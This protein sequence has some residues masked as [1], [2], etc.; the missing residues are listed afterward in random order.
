M[1]NL[2]VFIPNDPN[3]QAKHDQS[4]INYPEIVFAPHEY[5]VIDVKRSAW[6]VARIWF[7]ALIMAILF[8]VFTVLVGQNVPG[9]QILTTSLLG[10][11]MV[12]VSFIGGAIATSVFRQ[13]C[14][15]AT[16]ER[17]YM[18]IQHTPF[19]FRVQNIEMENIEDCSYAQRGLLQ[20]MLGYG[21]LRLSTIGDE[22]TYP[23]TFVANPEQQ[24]TVVNSI[25]QAVDQDK[26]IR[27]SGSQSPSGPGSTAP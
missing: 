22:Q 24:F 5:V 1:Q 3:W 21:S 7:F 26:P 10:F 27:F 19:S 15:I 20:M 16:S 17:V 4:V 14:M 13:N 8:I 11:L 12:I 18:R 9:N 25:V 23:F 2:P 6:G